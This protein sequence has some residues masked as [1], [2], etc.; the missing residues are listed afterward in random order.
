MITDLHD[1]FSDFDPIGLDELNAKAEMLARIDN[2]YILPAW[3][4]APALESFADMFDVLDIDGTR[5]FR[6]S[7][8][9][10]DDVD[11][12]GYYD[13]HQRRRKRLKARVRSY[14]DA[15][16]HYLEVKLND[17]RSTTLKKRLRL[18]AAT[19]QLDAEALAFI[20][21]CHAEV[22]GEPFRKQLSGAIHIRYRRYTLVAKDGGERMTLDTAMTFTAGGVTA[23]PPADTF[24]I[25][26]KSARGNGIADKILRGLHVQPTK[27]VSKYCIGLAACGQVLRHNGFLPAM[28]RLG[29]A[30][31]STA[32][33]SANIKS[34]ERIQGRLPAPAYRPSQT[35]HAGLLPALHG[36]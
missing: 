33:F 13:H 29:L 31:W 34:E 18:G 21:G 8:V 30:E 15:G 14:V 10:F 35:Y 24:I 26:T 16:L 32:Q 27:R 6:Y 17:R 9:Y 22:Y 19:S 1:S 7:T 12:R 36:V 20:D 25:E 3:Q 28:R 5:D 2:K 11:L 23:S 4:L